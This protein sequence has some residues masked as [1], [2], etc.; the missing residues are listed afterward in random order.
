MPE[1]DTALF[2]N[3]VLLMGLLSLQVIARMMTHGLP[4][5]LS[6]LDEDRNESVFQGRTNRVARNQLEFTVL[7][8]AVIHLSSAPL[9]NAG[10]LAVFIVAARIA[11]VAVALGG[12]AV[13]RSATW[14]AS[15]AALVFVATQTVQF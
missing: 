14:V 4:F 12:I 11:Y 8:I 13:A 7:L 5:A 2:A 10:V 3:V 1:I 9:E 15:F 6:S